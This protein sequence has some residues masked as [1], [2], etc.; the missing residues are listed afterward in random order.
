[1][2]PIVKRVQH[3]APEITNTRFESS[4]YRIHCNHGEKKIQTYMHCMPCANATSDSV[5]SHS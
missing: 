4:T 3:G 5:T 1:M 2:N